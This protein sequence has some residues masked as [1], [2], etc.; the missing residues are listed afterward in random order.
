MKKRAVSRPAPVNLEREAKAIRREFK[1]L[2]LD[3]KRATHRYVRIGG[4]LARC[5]DRLP[6]GEWMRWMSKNL[7]FAHDWAERCIRLHHRFETDAKFRKLAESAPVSVLYI[8]DR[9][10]EMIDAILE[11][12]ESGEAITHRTLK[13]V[14]RPTITVA[15][16]P[17][18]PSATQGATPRVPSL[19]MPRQ[20]PPSQPPPAPEPSQPPPEPKSAEELAAATALFEVLDAV[21]FPLP[22]TDVLAEAYRA[23]PPKVSAVEFRE[24]GYAS[25]WLARELEKD[26]DAT[27]AETPPEGTRH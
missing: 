21:E 16:Y 10:P 18:E 27:P 7:A 15:A 24:I 4:L 22:D 5:K 25:L 14:Q 17:A 11:R 8:L 3:L 23:K 20:S 12:H 6:H 13:I 1:L 19:P 2:C 26:D 9:H